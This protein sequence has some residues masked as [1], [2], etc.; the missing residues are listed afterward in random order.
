MRG[1][2]SILSLY[3]NESYKCIN[4]GARMLVS[5]YHMTLKLLFKSRVCHNYI[6]DVIMDVTNS[7]V[8]L[9][10]EIVVYLF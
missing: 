3:R 2:Q 9:N 1:L 5:I 7:K 8:L 10:S 6:R 4:T